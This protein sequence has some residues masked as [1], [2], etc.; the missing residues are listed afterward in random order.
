MAISGIVRAE[1]DQ[2][3]A[4]ANSLPVEIMRDVVERSRLGFKIRRDAGVVMLSASDRS[5]LRK[6]IGGGSQSLRTAGT[7]MRLSWRFLVEGTARAIIRR[8]Q[9]TVVQYDAFVGPFRDVG[10]LVPAHPSGA[11]A[12][13]S[14][15]DA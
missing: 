8:D 3:L 14:R 11:A 4:G 10:V 7:S 1:V 12:E 13:D 15:E 9:L 6:L 2:F 5:W